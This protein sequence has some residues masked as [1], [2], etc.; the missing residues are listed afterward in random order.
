MLRTTIQWIN[1]RL[2]ERLMLGIDSL[3]AS[4]TQRMVILGHVEHHD[5]LEQEARR[6]DAEGKP[7]L[8]EMI[9]QQAKTLTFPNDATPKFSETQSIQV[10]TPVVRPQTVE[11]PRIESPTAAALSHDDGK[12]IPTSKVNKS[13]PARKGANQ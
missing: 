2:I 4:T 3:L 6:Y 10:S 11:T 1:D 7:H 5:Q 12:P 8:A 9:R 13:K